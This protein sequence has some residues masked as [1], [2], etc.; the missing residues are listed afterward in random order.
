MLYLMTVLGYMLTILCYGSCRIGLQPALIL[1]S[2]L[3]IDSPS[4]D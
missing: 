2:R 4:G 3:A 1:I